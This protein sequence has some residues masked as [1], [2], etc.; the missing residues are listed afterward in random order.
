M[1]KIREII[2]TFF[3]FL[4]SIPI[5]LIYLE[6]KKLG[7][8][9]WP[10]L[11]LA[12]FAFIFNIFL[13]FKIK[14]QKTKKTNTMDTGNYKLMASLE[15]V[16]KSIIDGKY[17][18]IASC[19]INGQVYEVKSIGLNYNPKSLIYKFDLKEI[20]V[21]ISK[22]DN[23]P[24]LVDDDFFITYMEKRNELGKDVLAN[25]ELKENFKIGI[26]LGF[27]NLL[28]CS[29]IVFILSII[30]IFIFKD[31][32]SF[33]DLFNFPTI[34]LLIAIFLFLKRKKIR[35]N[36]I[37]LVGYVEDIVFH[38]SSS[39]HNSY[40]Q[41]IISYVYNKKIYVTTSQKIYNRF[42][43]DIEFLPVYILPKHPA[44]A[45]VDISKLSK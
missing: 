1:K 21:F 23:K 39:N 19:T 25:L 2:S 14:K 10:F 44:D 17:I 12:I 3:F 5:F 13:L 27:L 16:D 37:F 34:I 42:N 9:F 35:K 26:D 11:L 8:N 15:R 41:I 18:V 38:C 6:L 45:Y 4:F 28:I 30:L 29:V 43:K 24:I 40:W 22:E 7:F 33:F 20:P 32:N 36:G 31:T